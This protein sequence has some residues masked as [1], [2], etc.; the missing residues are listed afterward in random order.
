MQTKFNLHKN[1]VFCKNCVVSN[2]RPSLIPE[3][4]DT[5][6]R[7]GANYLKIDPKTGW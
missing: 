4:H 2:Q 7:K 5:K 1:I 6:N 3:F